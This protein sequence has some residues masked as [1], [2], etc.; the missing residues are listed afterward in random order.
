MVCAARS[1]THDARARRRDACSQL[2]LDRRV[3]FAGYKVPHPLI[4]DVIFKVQ[5]EGDETYTPLNAFNG[6]LD[7]LKN[8]FAHLRTSFDGALRKAKG[9]GADAYG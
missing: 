6:A 7:D 9:D 3:R 8:E 2:L 5:T 1:I 4:H